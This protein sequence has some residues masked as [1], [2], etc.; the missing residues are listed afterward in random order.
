MAVVYRGRDTALDREVAVKL[1]HPHLASAPESRARFSREA[2]AVARLSHPGIVEIYD[3]SG[4]GAA[5]SYLVTEYVR[6][7][8]LR[9]FAAE[10]GFG[11]PELSALVGR[12]LVDALV[13]AHSAGVIHRD[14]KPENVLVHEG[15]RPAVKLADFGIARIL[16]SD[17]RMTMTG[18]LVGS[19]H[20]MA[21][22]IVEG[23]EADA[24]SDLFSLGTI[25]Y[26][27]ATG[28]LP[29]AASNPT[30]I[31]R[32]V[33]EADFEDPRAADPRV[34]DGLAELILRCLSLA[35]EKR[36]ASAAEVRDALDRLLAESGLARPEEELVAFLR[37]PAAF[38]ASFPP[39][40]VAALTERGDAVLAGGSPARALGFYSRVLAIDPGNA[41]IP[42]KLARLSR[43][44]RLRRTAAFSS[45]GV[46]LAAG[47]AAV[48]ALAPRPAVAP[49]AG[50]PPARPPAA[51]ARAPSGA[52][53]PEAPGA[54]AAPEAPEPS[55]DPPA[56][57]TQERSA[58]APRGARPGGPGAP[59]EGSAPPRPPATL[60][61]HVRPYA[62]RALLDGV[63]VA[64][65]EQLV[66]FSLAPGRPHV[67]QLD[68]A[69]C[70]PFVREITAEEAQRVGELR[71][72]LVPRPAR[73][74]VEGDPATRV[75]VDGKLVGTAGESQR[76]AFAIPV[77]GGAESP[78]EAPARIGLEIAG[79]AAR[80]V[81]VKLR[82]GGEVVVAAPASAPAPA[83]VPAPGAARPAAA[84]TQP[85]DARP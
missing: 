58:P 36:P 9:A 46:A 66:R 1:L 11:F 74:R 35:P 30:A 41:E 34:P 19:P 60:T 26:W 56:A 61:V 20:H 13:H 24:R 25:L 63:E 29:F 39:R 33:L 4:D 83:P 21:P 12:A 14:L 78:Y 64:R 48:I 23:R 50:A 47:I 45:A 15:E 68:H 6:G 31:L 42:A 54:D 73:L 8:T 40:A 51:E 65:G 85:G 53:T 49:P 32:R 37:D 55:I 84:S 18:A 10:V 82:A 71:V 76:T 28:K 3:Y 2:R 17:E 77:P 79:A 57:K 81:Q 67:I 7:R 16:A 70:A 43:R 27:L 62:Q 80:D 5:D 44:R 52:P 69:C 38:K 22:E 72:P 75:Y 59:R